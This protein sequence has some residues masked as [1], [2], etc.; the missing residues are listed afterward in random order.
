M[1]SSG[2][3]LCRGLCCLPRRAKGK[4]DPSHRSPVDGTVEAELSALRDTLQQ[5]DLIHRLI[6]THPRCLGFANNAHAAWQVFQ[7]GRIASFIGVEGLHQIGGSYSALRL[8]RRL[9]VQYV[10]LCHTRHNDFVD[11]SVGQKRHEAF[12]PAMV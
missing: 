7:S 1:G 3:R 4:V 6:E 5:I 12:Q 9:G 8:F 10:T 2:A 11:S